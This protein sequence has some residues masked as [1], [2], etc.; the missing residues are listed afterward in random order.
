MIT[1]QVEAKDGV[2]V[3]LNNSNNQLD[4][5][6]VTA[7]GVKR[8]R[9]ALGYAAQDLKAE[10]LN[11]EG[12][13]SLASAIQGKLTGVSVRQSSGAPGASAQIVIRGARSFDGNNAPLY[14]IDG[15][16]ISTTPDFSTGASV[17][18]A[19]IYDTSFLKLRDVTITYN[20]PKIGKFD[21]S[22]YGFA[23]N[24]LVWAKLPNFDP[25]SSQGN[26][27]MSGYFE[28]FSV[29]NAIELASSTTYNNEWNGTYGNL[30]N[31][32][33]IIAKT[34]EESTTTDAGQLDLMG[35]AQVLTA[36]NF[37]VLTDL[38]LA[39]R[40]FRGLTTFSLRSTSRKTCI[41]TSSPLSMLLSTTSRRLKM[42]AWLMW[43][44]R[45]SSMATTLSSGLLPLTH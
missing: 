44:S 28:R 25:E 12:T 8:D 18:E 10:E 11:T 26:G 20:L 34:S 14:V 19:G 21:I 35:M 32:K 23:R 39:Q 33:Q 5:V 43:A 27:N 29:R 37:G 41:N 45:T 22:V 42:P 17:T 36:L 24:I 2:V 31:L 4:E 6:V 13:T 16:P 9:K 30:M 1:K 40:L 7:M 15:M 38:H 3:T